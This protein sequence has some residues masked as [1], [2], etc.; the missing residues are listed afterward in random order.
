MHQHA[1]PGTL[2]SPIPGPCLVP[3]PGALCLTMWRLDMRCRYAPTCRGLCVLNRAQHLIGNKSHRWASN[4]HP[5]R[6]TSGAAPGQQCT[7]YDSN[8][9]VTRALHYL[10]S[11]AMRPQ[12]VHCPRATSSGAARS[13]PAPRQ[14]ASHS[15]IDV[16]APSQGR[17][18]NQERGRGDLLCTQN[19]RKTEKRKLTLS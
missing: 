6:P 13:T 8:A 2:L 15:R 11:S 17:Q 12:I 14:Q 7:S 4:G 18:F 19:H 10:L 16:D 3:P 1:R 9:L 5:N